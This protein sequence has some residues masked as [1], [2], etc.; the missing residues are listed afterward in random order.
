MFHIVDPHRQ[1]HQTRELQSLLQIEAV[2]HNYL[3]TFFASADALLAP[4]GVMVMQAI[5]TP[6]HRYEEYIRST[7][8]INTIIFPGNEFDFT[9]VPLCFFIH[10]V[11]PKPFRQLVG[12]EIS[13]A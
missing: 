7:D 10:G 1:T 2:G 13:S 9:S 5:T 11:V 6:E 3:G 4:G 8:F 12:F